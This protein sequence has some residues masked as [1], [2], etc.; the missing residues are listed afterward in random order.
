MPCERCNT[1]R[2]IFMIVALAMGLISVTVLAMNYVD[3]S[4]SIDAMTNL[5]N[6]CNLKIQECNNKIV[7]CGW[8]RVKAPE[9][10]MTSFN[11][12]WD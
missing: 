3:N 4:A 5:T 2:M 9:P 8:S 10:N 7:L 6:E 1:W 11:K 12:T